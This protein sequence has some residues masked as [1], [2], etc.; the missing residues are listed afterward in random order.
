VS[1]R[2]RIPGHLTFADS[3][4][5]LP[6]KLVVLTL[7]T[8]RSKLRKPRRKPRRRIALREPLL[9]RHRVKL[10]NFGLN[11]PTLTLLNIPTLTLLLL[12]TLTR[13]K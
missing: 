9:S 5:G 12:L 4:Q 7:N 1:C 13:S 10:L 11:I 8:S 6:L 2:R 3:H